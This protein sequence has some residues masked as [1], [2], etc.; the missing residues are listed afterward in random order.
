[1]NLYH[2]SHLLLLLLIPLLVI[3]LASWNRRIKERFS[4]YAEGKFF[5]YYY[6]TR[7]GFFSTLKIVLVIMAFFMVVIALVRPQ[8][9]YESKDFEAMGM[10]IVLAI[11][12]SKSMDATD[13]LPTRLLRAKMQITAFID[14]L[15]TDR[16]ALVAFAGDAS[17]ECP[18]TDD[19]ETVK[20]ILNSLNTNTITCLG[21]DIGK[22]MDKSLEAFTNSG[23][24]RVLILISDGE[25]LEQSAIA[26]AAQLKANGIVIYTM[27]VGSE[28][29]AQISHPL[30]GQTVTTKLDVETLK[31]IAAAGGGEFYAV[32]PN[33]AELHYLLER[34]YSTE[35]GHLY[36]RNLSM[37]K[38]QYHIFVF[39]ALF[40]L[41][42]ESLLSSRNFKTR[43]LKEPSR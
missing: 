11:D 10:D 26:K 6:Q 35:K 23:G 37:M 14:K 13:M 25:D 31:K 29:G 24:S 16:L 5:G 36:S 1:M 17:I 43:A 42:L 8:W 3:I 39:A 38:E 34:I 4:Q 41:I 15:S 9:D 7:S 30:Y 22:A 32:T 33:Q 19:Y 40:L 28:A 2:Q 27:G 20:L 12:V 18:L 21:T